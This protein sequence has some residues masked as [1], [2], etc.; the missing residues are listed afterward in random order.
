MG[1]R[2]SMKSRVSRVFLKW[3]QEV[4]SSRELRSYDIEWEESG[5]LSPKGTQPDRWSL[6]QSGQ[7][8]GW[9]SDKSNINP[10]GNEYR[11]SYLNIRS[12]SGRTIRRNSEQDRE[13]SRMEI[14]GEGKHKRGSILSD[15][16]K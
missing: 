6:S 1:P 9:K 15:I 8:Q 14:H 3:F 7:E 4:Q 10:K 11:G 5:G 13:S 16:M 2:V 12:L